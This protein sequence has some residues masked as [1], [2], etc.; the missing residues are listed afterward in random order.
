MGEFKRTKQNNTSLGGVFDCLYD[1]HFTLLSADDSLF[2]LLGYTRDEFLTLFHN[3]FIE[4]IYAEE[5]ANVML[6]I[7]VQ[8]KKGHV[9]MYENRLVC[10]NGDLKWIWISA[11]ILKNDKGIP[12]FHCIFHDTTKEKNTYENLIISEKRFQVIVSQ[13]QDIIFEMDVRNNHVYYSD[14]FEKKFGYR[15]PLDN[16]PASMFE[17]DIIYEED[18]PVLKDAFQSLRMGSN[19]M[20]CEYRLKYRNQG[21]HWVEAKT[22]TIRDEQGRLLSM[23]G[24]ITD[25]N[26]TKETILQ[27]IKEAD[28]DSLTGLY[29]R[30]GFLKNFDEILTKYD[31]CM[32]LLIDLDDFKWFNDNLGH[33]KGDQVLYSVSQA[34]KQTFKDQLIGRYGGDEFIICAVQPMSQNELKQKVRDIQNVFYNEFSEEQCVELG[35]SIGACMYPLHGDNFLSLFHKAD[36]AMYEA[37]KNGKHQFMMYDDYECFKALPKKLMKK[38][39]HDQNLE[40]IIGLFMNIPENCDGVPILLEHL[41]QLFNCDRIT[42]YKNQKQTYCWCLKPDYEIMDKMPPASL[43]DEQCH[44]VFYNDIDT[45]NQPELRAWFKQRKTLA[46]VLSQVKG[47]QYVNL[48]ICL[49]DCHTKR[50]V[51]EES[52]YSIQMICELAAVLII[53]KHAILSQAQDNAAW[54]SVIM[55]HLAVGVFT[56]TS[57]NRIVNINSAMITM[58]GYQDRADYFN[59]TQ[60]MLMNSICPDDRLSATESVKEQL[61]EK[62]TFECEYRMMKKDGSWFWVNEKGRSIPGEPNEQTTISVCMD[63]TQHKECQN[64]LTIYRNSSNGGTFVNLL[65][66]G[67]HTLLY[68]NDIFYEI[69]DITPASLQQK[70]Y[71]CLNL[72]HPDDRQKVDS[73]LEN[74]LEQHLE[75]VNFEFRAITDKGVIKW[76]H[77]HG[78]LSRLA[79]QPVLNGF[80]TDNT[81]EHQLI[82]QLEHKETLYRTALQQSHINVWEYNVKEKALFLT[83]SAVD[84]HSLNMI[85]S[86]IPDSIIERGII[87]PMSIPIVKDMYKKL[88]EGIPKIQADVLTIDKDGIHWWWERIHYHM[89]YDEFGMP[90]TAVAIGEDV[91][92]Q[93]ETQMLYQKELFSQ[94]IQNKDLIASFKGNITKNRIDYIEGVAIKDYEVLTYD[95]I[96]DLQKKFSASSEDVFRVQ[97]VLS[98]EAVLEAYSHG[99][100]F[101]TCDYRRKDRHGNLSWVRALSKTFLDGNGNDLHMLGVLQDIET[102]K[103]LESLIHI[104][105]EKE[106]LTGVY[107]KNT[108]AAMIDEVLVRA[109][110]YHKPFALLLF[111]VDSSNFS[112]LT[113]DNI[114]KVFS[115][116]ASH[117]LLCFSKSKLVGKLYAGEFAVFIYNHFDEMSITRYINEIRQSMRMYSIIPG[118]QEPIDITFGAAIDRTSKSFDELYHK[119]KGTMQ[120]MSQSINLANQTEDDRIH[121]TLEKGEVDLAEFINRFY[122]TV[123][124]PLN[125]VEILGEIRRL[126]ECERVFLYD[127]PYQQ[128]YESMAEHAQLQSLKSNGKLLLHIDKIKQWAMDH[129]DGSLLYHEEMKELRCAETL[130]DSKAAYLLV[131]M[132]ED[133]QL[134]AVIG[135]D[136]VRHNESQLRFL[137]A[138]QSIIIHEWRLYRFKEESE[139]DQELDPL[140]KVK[141]RISF[142]NYHKNLPVDTLIAM[143]V[144]MVDINGL[145]DLNKRYGLKYGDD[146]MIRLAN[147]L[148]RE[149]TDAD[150]YRFDSD[151]FLMV[152]KNITYD[153]FIKRITDIKDKAEKI[154][155]VTV[156]ASWAE[157]QI[158]L[159]NLIDNAIEQRDMEKQLHHGEFA[160][161]NKN[162][163]HAQAHK[164]LNEALKKQYLKMYLQQKVN[165][166][167]GNVIGAE[168]LIRYQDTE[169]GLIG[170]NRFIP[171]LEITGLIFYVDFFIFEEV[172]K[173]LAM[174]KKKGIA[175]IPISL[176]F[177]RVTLLGDQLV[178]R[179]NQINQKYDIDR[180]LIEIEITENIGEIERN[181]VIKKCREIKAAG[182]HL[183]LDDFGAKFSN[184]AIISDIQFDTLKFDKGLVD[185]LVEN[186]NARW[187]LESIIKLCRRMDIYNVAEGVEIKEQVDILAE[188]GCTYIQGYIYSRPVIF[189]RFDTSHN[190]RE[191]KK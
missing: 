30:R 20:Q 8:L 114:N 176:N 53:R 110:A 71:R 74:A 26:K 83:E 38:S 183:A 102:I 68:A 56:C 46:A 45:I 117:L 129:E 34:L 52:K 12:Y 159:Y 109:P 164:K 59:A 11:Q 29:N 49:E 27:T 62:G 174:W 170:P 171:Y 145:K 14:N 146:I 177:S 135:I 147:T 22:T 2:Q 18:K 32:L 16:F 173:L 191:H 39:Y 122:Y 165:S 47:N 60:G 149:N 166:A 48:T 138:L 1:E 132:L 144:I 43:N 76:I 23:I 189:N 139:S 87:H 111:H 69:Y 10:K 172:H 160:M 75:N 98:K 188:L 179:M 140:T 126:Y 13:T 175:L 152:F 128:L 153:S 72:V 134:T 78:T 115:E 24:V 7:D 85:E 94:V 150:V 93:K 167:N 55:D 181:T 99:N 86:N 116:L 143:G 185:Y 31:S 156:G 131:P 180:D 50:V 133:N 25:I 151:E 6:E 42:V 35:L 67:A 73:I 124:S 70:E 15:I 112:A 148:T 130:L 162:D 57:D 80:I 168:A 137:K 33:L 58:L 79:D 123:A 155:S 186:E 41:G 108:L 91:T 104:N 184:I 40:A 96:L 3:H 103:V 182:Y 157:K 158:S 121:I 65:D 154:C 90:D 190:C 169:H 127:V 125:T 142:F 100:N 101:I 61:K 163:S 77:L 161:I 106:P 92:K 88:G 54:Q 89:I 17:G 119:A 51:M 37:K 44:T 19:D 120:D 113:D 82:E 63:F 107:T 97:K 81:L 118:V 178:E 28:Y 64:Q 84:M 187:I 36:A 105:V 9:F 66:Q 95:D 5:K 21:Y 141:N 4:I 136:G